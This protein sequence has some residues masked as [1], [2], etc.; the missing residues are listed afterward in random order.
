MFQKILVANRG[1]I[2]VRVI[3]AC[4]EMGIA[5]AAI[6][7]E[8]DRRAA[9]V[10]LADEAFFIGPAPA[11]QSYLNLERVIA[12]ALECGAQ[13]IHPGYGFLSENEQ[14]AKAAQDA[15]LIFIGPPPAAIAAMGDKGRAR[16]LVQS[17]GV[18][19]VPG[20]QDGLEDEHTLLELAHQLGFPVLVKAAAGGGG[21]GMRVV[22]APHE[23]TDGVAAAQ[24]EALHAFG[25]GRLILERYIPKAR[26][27]EFQVLADNYGNTLHL[28]ERECSVQ[29]RHQKIIEET[30]SPFLQPE[31]RQRMGAAAVAAA[32]AVGYQNAGT[33]EFIVDPQHEQFYF[34]EM[35]TRLQVEHPVT[36]W[37]TGLDLVQWQI[38]IAAGE[39]LSFYQ[40][41]VHQHGHA[42]ECRLYAEDPA[43]N[44]LPA[45]GAL[46]K[47]VEPSGP[48]VR[49]DAG[50]ASGDEISIH[51]D[52][53]IAKVIVWGED[54][55]AAIRRMK[56]ALRETVLL[57][58]T[59]NNY[60]LQDVLDDIDFQ[61]GSV[62]T[63]WVEDHFGDWQPPDCDPPPEV[64]IA[65]AL[66]QSGGAG[67]FSQQALASRDPFSPWK[68]ASDSRPG[69]QSRERQTSYHKG[70]ALR[71]RFQS[72]DRIY[73][74]ELEA[75][76][77]IGR[78]TIDGQEFEFEVL[79]WQ[80]G[81]ISLL[82]R[83]R[84]AAIFHASDETSQQKERPV[85]WL[86]MSGCTYRLER[87][88][89]NA[90]QAAPEAVAGGVVRAPM[91]AQV[92]AVQVEEGQ[93][94]EAGQTLLLLE[95]MKMEIRVRAPAAGR[96][97]RL[98]AAEGQAVLKEQ[99]L[100]E[101]EEQHAG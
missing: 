13:A 94:V 77:E 30:P 79:D 16:S 10:R 1:E 101:M 31:L 95:A 85:F 22:L 62:H 72:G 56:A 65:A 48:G 52:P 12:A 15:G 27:I 100:V 28:F 2:A 46:L 33:I 64:L 53:L 23:M 37:V 51:Y 91:P 98:L 60:F 80:P 24:R 7:S 9:H 42:I 75:S 45:T 74:V 55:P 17:H 44:F 54:R 82:V 57:G 84:P 19:V 47:F 39:Q 40:A 73:E 50:Y 5:S 71:K 81:Q 76:G 59:N 49:V 26:H 99:V 93:F 69:V 18:P 29:R 96:I 86:S 83:G 87:S 32:Q 68:A 14:F 11:T 6:Y 92:R 63:T 41:D 89:P 35:N 66:M 38:R 8:A 70:S 58:L 61:R 34:L 25:D 90:S 88:R 20:Y 4:R 21:K 97:A 36:E 67:G 3:R 78:A 43:N